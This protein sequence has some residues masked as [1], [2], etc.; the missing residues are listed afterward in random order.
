[1]NMTL[2]HVRPSV[3]LLGIALVALVVRLVYLAE[4]SGDPLLSVLMGDSRVYDQ[5]AQQLAGGQWIGTEVFYQTPLYPYAL[6]VIFKIAGHSLG[7]IR[8]IQA[9]LGAASCALLGLAGRRFFSDRVGV[10]AALLLAFY[11]PAIFFDG[12]I[13]KSSLDIFLIT[14]VLASLAQFQGSR[15]WRWLI[16]MGAIT[17]ALVLNRENARVLYPVI[18]AWLLFHFRDVPVRR[19]VGWA[20]V[21]LSATFVVLIP[22]GVRNYW[23]GGEFLLS[24]SQLGPN[25]FIGNNANA[26][27]SYDSLVPGRGDAV[28]ER[29][30]ATAL[31]S[32]ALGRPLSPGEVSDYWLRESF[33]YIRTQPTQWLALV[34]KKVLLTLNAAEIPDTESIEAYAESSRMLGGLLWFNFG[35]VLPMAALGCW[36]YR[37]QWRPLLILYGMVA[38]LA[39]AV[40]AF[41]VVAR[42]RH[43]LVPILLLLAAAGL[44]AM[45]E[46][47][48]VFT[49]GGVFTPRERDLQPRADTRRAVAPKTVAGRSPRGN[50]H[51][52]PVSR[53]P[54]VP[55]GW[56]REW[57][58]G[59]AAAGLLA[60]V[61]H[62]P[63]KVV[64]DQ[65]YINLGAFLVQTGRAADAVP[66]LLKAI[67]V[68][69]SYA[70][71]HLNLG[72]AYRE[73][74]AQQ[75]ALEELATAVRLGPDSAEAHGAL[76]LLLRDLGRPSDAL[77][78]LREAARL[79]PQSVEA[80]SNLGLAL[81]ETGQPKEAIVEHRR[82]VALAPDSP[83]PHNNLAVALQQTGDV[84]QAVAEYR[85][86][87]L[88]KPD[89]VEAHSNLALALAS[90]RDYAG[91]FRHFGE[92]IRIQPD[93]FGVRINFG[94]ALCEAGRTAEG[95]GQ[96]QEAGR[97]SPDSIDPLLLS[98]RAY[99][100]TGRFA[101]AIA[102]LEKALGLANATGRTDMVQQI[103]EALR[104]TKAMME[105][106]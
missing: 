10:V 65:T 29:A 28:Y 60:I 39:L 102:N 14:L 104:Q 85:T 26:S 64:H 101:D 20:A 95:I 5:W 46:Q 103:N 98:A 11:P 55:Q 18:G 57:I 2:R 99:A 58:P 16:A 4:L 66:V 106:R 76:G 53:P 34:G 68:D 79:L 93:S 48:S 36:A 100:R 70:A 42:Y 67:A 72:L 41:Y 80:H 17:A 1:M 94:N 78:H 105:R 45:L 52:A 62:I 82:A 71:P 87:L 31:A 59:L 22:V 63:M 13:Q 49:Q 91:A 54:R 47:F 15:R 86:A 44:G 19:R 24:T 37:R 25:F 88:I 92:A 7:L 73:T 27:G 3:A 12:L 74:G 96:Y 81:M 56:S 50:A 8:I 33:A 30:D 89:D 6:A 75:A 35:V 84:Q 43:P 23:V 69:P 21:F 32:K 61:S 77:P 40:A 90:S 38:S 9:I 83:T 97:L 51:K